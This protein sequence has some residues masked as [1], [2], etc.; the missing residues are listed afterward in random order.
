MK[1]QAKSFTACSL[2]AFYS[3]SLAMGM[4]I[5]QT[6]STPPTDAPAILNRD[7][8]SAVLPPSVFFRGQSATIQARNSA[9]IRL[10]GGKLVLVALVDT[11]GYSSA[12]QQTY[13][14]YLITEVQL[15]ISGQTLSPGAYG[16]GFVAGKMVVMDIGGNE[17]L[18]AATTRDT[19]I[20]RPTPLQIVSINGSNRLYLGRDFVVLAT[21]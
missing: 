13:Q 9:G 1:V 5:G 7:Q 6:A 2:L 20:A 14:A 10:Q 16:F 15:T 21:R 11:S 4:A 8:A 19:A 18:H 12:I 3:V 17:I